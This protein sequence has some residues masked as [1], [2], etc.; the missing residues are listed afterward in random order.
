VH[1]QSADLQVLHTKP[2]DHQAPDGEAAD[3]YRADGKR[4]NSR[5][6][7]GNSEVRQRIRTVGPHKVFHR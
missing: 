5:K 3:G 4:A 6:T 2:L 1:R 7:R